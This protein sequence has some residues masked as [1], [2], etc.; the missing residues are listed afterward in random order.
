MNTATSTALYFRLLGYVR[1]YWKA[2]AA[3]VCGIALVALSE[4]SLPIAMKPFLDGTFVHKDPFV[5]KWIPLGFVG[6][7]LVRGIGSFL[8]SYAIN[9]VGSKVVQ[10]LRSEMFSKI[11]RLPT[12]YFDNHQSGNIIS[13]LTFDATQVTAA[14][15]QVVNV[16][17][18]DGLLVIGLLAWLFYLNWK[19]TLITFV[20]VPPIAL[21]VRVFSQR[22]R[23]TSRAMQQA[24]GDINNVL[25]EAIECHKVV[26][27][28]GGALYEAR[29]FQ[30]ATGR[31]RHF[32]MKQVVAGSLNVPITQLLV[33]IA[34]AVVIYQVTLQAAA[35]TT[36]VGGFVS[37]IG[38]MVLLS[39]P[40]KRLASMSE[41]MQRGLA[42]SESIFSLLDEKPELDQG[43]I[44]LGHARG[45]IAFEAVSLRY[46][47][48]E[49]EALENIQLTIGAGETVALVGQSGSGKTSLANLMARFYLPSAGRITLD[50]H[51]LAAITLQSL[52]ANVGIVSQDVS[53]FNDT[54]AANI[55]YGIESH[56]DEAQIRAAAKVAHALEFI[57]AMPQ[58]LQTLVGENGVR[59]SGGQRQRLAIA[60][61]LLKNAP[62]LIL[63]EATSAL[64]TESERQVQAGL[65]ALMQGR[66]TLVIAHR[67]STIENADRIV[68]MEA[69]RIVETGTHTELLSNAG[70]YARLHALQF[71]T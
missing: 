28:F 34:I 8:G 29:R 67:L 70:P 54:I 60:R 2:F 71:R 22:L 44:N 33:A 41:Y 6:V 53:L 66:T 36:T 61:T 42:A 31:F 49:R 56:A 62:V 3:S 48:S 38:A 4:V 24:M 59:L 20:M 7:F 64:D 43:T 69:G 65:E 16:L 57:E 15:T 27:V 26:K 39:A 35:D 10:D 9:W 23:E 55:S 37:F 30:E 50:G 58:G 13:K 32:Q 63:D 18:K 46:D 47:S 51:D 68:V 21:V 12:P 1:P 5:M 52:R 25:Q 14:A 40:T 11:L 17:V 19:L 45:D